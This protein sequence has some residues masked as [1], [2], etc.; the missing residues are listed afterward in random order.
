VL[1]NNVIGLL[2]VPSHVCS[3]VGRSV[4]NVVLRGTACSDSDRLANPMLDGL[5]RPTAASAAVLDRAS[6]QYAPSTDIN[7]RRRGRAPDIGAYEY[8]R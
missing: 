8:H 7:G 1:A 3:Q 6:P 5:G 2:A 4:A